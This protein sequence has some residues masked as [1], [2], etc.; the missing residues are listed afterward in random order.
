MDAAL[1]NVRIWAAEGATCWGSDTKSLRQK[2][3]VKYQVLFLSTAISFELV[4]QSRIRYESGFFCCS[5]KE[6]AFD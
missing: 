6:R 1:E 2:D 4:F 3:R 5:Q